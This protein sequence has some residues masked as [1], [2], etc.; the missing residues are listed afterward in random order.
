MT[1][2]VTGTTGRS[3][4]LTI[5]G[6]AV[7]VPEGTTLLEACRMQ[8]IATPT[9][10]YLENLRPVNVCRVCVV[11]VEGSRALVPA[12]SRRAE[13]GMVVQTDSERVR[14]S[15]R[16][17]L[18]LLASSVDLSLAQA[19]AP[20]L[21]RYGVR[22]ALRRPVAGKERDARQAGHHEAPEGLAQKRWH[23]R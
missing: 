2:V 17:V 20:Y 19:L 4:S 3:I 18:E 21:E 5:D 1:A 14:L 22:P 7:C 10:C 11:E 23:S 12:C 8:G 6:Q 13:S 16:L 15:R 9:L